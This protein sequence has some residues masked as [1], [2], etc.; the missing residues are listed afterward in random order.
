M[1]AKT[2]KLGHGRYFNQGGKPEFMRGG[3]DTR[4]RCRHQL[5]TSTG[6]TTLANFGLPDLPGMQ[7]YVSLQPNTG[8]PDAAVDRQLRYRNRRRPDQWRQH[9]PVNDEI[10][11]GSVTCPVSG[12]VN[13]IMRCI[14][15]TV[16]L[17]RFHPP[18]SVRTSWVT[19]INSCDEGI[20]WAMTRSVRWRPPRGNLWR[21]GGFA[22]LKAR[23]TYLRHPADDA[24]FRCDRPLL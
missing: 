2:F 20:I 16:T 3:G 13:N 10:G 9:L 22:I 5:A 6:D 18:E 19:N 15:F 23:K 21:E 17:G 1:V 24:T 4:T 11:P 7:R 12:N 14:A 8:V